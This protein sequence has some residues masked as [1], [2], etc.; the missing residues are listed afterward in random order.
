TRNRVHAIPE[1]NG[2]AAN[3]DE[4]GLLRKT[5]IHG[6]EHRSS[7]KGWNRRRKLGIGELPEQRVERFEIHVQTEAPFLRHAG[8]PLLRKLL[9]SVGGWKVEEVVHARHATIAQRLRPSCES[10][11]PRQLTG[12][13]EEESQRLLLSLFSGC[14]DESVGIYPVALM[15]DTYGQRAGNDGVATRELDAVDERSLI[16]C[17]LFR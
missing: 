3:D 14:C 13:L 9:R 4:A 11:V 15:P 7:S 2:A 6:D 5:S 17:F 10:S 8:C 1:R 12:E 16:E